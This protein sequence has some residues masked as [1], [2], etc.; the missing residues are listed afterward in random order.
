MQSQDH[1]LDL[2]RHSNS[3]KCSVQDYEGD[4]I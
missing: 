3:N 1:S 4:G 2:S